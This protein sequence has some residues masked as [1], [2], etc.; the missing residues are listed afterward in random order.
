MPTLDPR[1]GGWGKLAATGIVLAFLAF[2]VSFALVRLA[3][4]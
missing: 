3:V 2:V 4:F 1:A